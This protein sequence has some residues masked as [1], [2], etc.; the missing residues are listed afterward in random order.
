MQILVT[1]FP[2]KILLVTSLHSVSLTPPVV[3]NLS[4]RLSSVPALLGALELEVVFRK[5]TTTLAQTFLA[6][7][8]MWLICYLFLNSIADLNVGASPCSTH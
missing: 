5:E 1:V 4:V 6:N 3:P 2:G 7:M 8:C